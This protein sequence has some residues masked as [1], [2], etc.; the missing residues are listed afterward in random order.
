V[1]IVVIKRVPR[2]VNGKTLG[3]FYHFDSDVVMYLAHC[4]G[5][6]DKHYIPKKNA[7]YFDIG[8][9]SEATRRNTTVIGIAHR[10]GKN[11]RYYVT[12][13]TNFLNDA[14]PYWGNKETGRSLEVG[15][16]M[17]NTALRPEVINKSML[18]SK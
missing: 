10:V 18:I 15:K 17:V 14:V 5:E 9:I 6:K 12:Y 2:T 16:F 11:I 8:T 1:G 3:T 4:V 13:M 7:W